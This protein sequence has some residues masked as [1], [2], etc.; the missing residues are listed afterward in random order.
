MHRWISRNSPRAGEEWRP[1]YD[2][3]HFE[4]ECRR[5]PVWLDEE[6]KGSE[7]LGK[8]ENYIVRHVR[9][10]DEDFS[11]SERRL[12]EEEER[13]VAAGVETGIKIIV[14]P[15]ALYLPYHYYNGSRWGIYFRVK[16]MLS[17]FTKFFAALSRAVP[18]DVS[19]SEAWRVYTMTVFWH[20]LAHHVI[21]D[22]AS[23][24]E[25]VKPASRSYPLLPR[26]VEERFCE[27]VAF[28]AAE[29]V[30][31]CHWEHEIPLLRPAQKWPVRA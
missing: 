12:I 25:G 17:D 29:N 1:R 7:E 30:Q 16:R 3:S 21:E 10:R 20:E 27:Y 13:R 2:L 23:A 28:N 22:I 18:A 24:L 26:V 6:F 4:A 14:D 5:P 31:K 15:L 9:V 8:L 11:E 19:V